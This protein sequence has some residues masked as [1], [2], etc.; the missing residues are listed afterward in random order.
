MSKRKLLELVEDGHV[1]G[2]DDPR[3][4]TI[5]GMRRRGY[6]SAAIRTF[7]KKVGISK[8]NSTIPVEL[9]EHCVRDELNKTAPRFM[10]V[11]RP[12]RVVLDNYPGETVETVQVENNPEDSDAG[13]R[14]VPFS[15]ELFIEQDDFM[16]RPPKK[17]FRL[18][19][20]REVRLKNAYFI[21]CE[22][23]VHDGE[24]APAVLH[25][26]L[27]R[28]TKGGNAPDG[29]R[30]RATLH[31][32]SARHAVDVE[33]RL[34]DR[35]FTVEDPTSHPGRDCTDFLNPTSRVVLHACKAEP[36]VRNLEPFSQ[37]QFLRQGYF[38]VDPDT[39]C[40]HV[41]FNRTVDLK[42]AWSR[43]QKKPTP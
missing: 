36:G 38:C 21:T 6:P 34:Y 33:V 7:C 9:L 37:V 5:R 8:A 39:T 19:P 32:V 40:E 42:D 20:G 29:R 22:D 17:F 11:L 23:V 31:W 14:E 26:T 28:A 12:L 30:P 43:L 24:G 10:C 16:E 35:L 3:L 27:D 15:R 25:C 2:W 1:G 18:A 41:V 4:P 13:V